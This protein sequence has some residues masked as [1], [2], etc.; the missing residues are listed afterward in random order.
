MIY[1]RIYIAREALHKL[2]RLAKENAGI[3]LY[4][5]IAIYESPHFPMFRRNGDI[6]WGVLIINTGFMVYLVEELYQV[7]TA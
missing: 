5:G 6:V 2:K 3:T 1:E 4:E 7:T